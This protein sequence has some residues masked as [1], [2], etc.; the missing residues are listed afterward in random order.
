LFGPSGIVVAVRDDLFMEI[1]AA[2]FQHEFVSPYLEHLDVFWRAAEQ[3]WDLNLWRYGFH[4]FGPPDA[5]FRIRRRSSWQPASSAADPARCPKC[6]AAC[7]VG[8]DAREALEFADSSGPAD[9]LSGLVAQGLLLSA[10]HRL[11]P[12]MCRLISGSRDISREN[13]GEAL[14]KTSLLGT[15]G[16]IRG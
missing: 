13:A 14:A 11:I 7:K 16:S 9:G 12:H 15:N 5:W 3:A 2:C 6:L 8:R 1:G 10:G 4:W